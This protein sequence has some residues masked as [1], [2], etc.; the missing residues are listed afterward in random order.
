MHKKSH[1]ILSDLAE[2]NKQ[3]DDE[4]SGG[5]YWTIGHILFSLF[6]GEQPLLTRPSDY[7]RLYHVFLMAG[8]L[9][10]YCAN[11]DSGGHPDS[12]SDLSVYAAM[13]KS[14]DEQI[15]ERSYG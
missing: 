8:K 14:M 9:S 1:E 5:D 3:K 13:V 4:Y 7:A 10:R 15:E 11:F 6:K 2:L 12:L